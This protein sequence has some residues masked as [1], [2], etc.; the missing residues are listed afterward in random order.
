MTGILRNAAL[1]ALL[2]CGV[3]GAGAQEAL[4]QGTTTIVVPFAAGGPADGVAR[5]L[6]E[7]LATRFKRKYI[8]ENKTG[9]GG[10]IGAATV[11]R[12]A[13]DGQTLLFAV[14]SILTVN[15]HLQKRQ[16]F[17]PEALV[18]MAQI[19][20]TVLLLAV[21]PEKVKAADFRAMVAESAGKEFSFGSAGVGSPGHLAFEY[22]KQVSGM[23]GVHVP[24]RG[25]ALALQDLLS[26]NIDATFIVSGVLVPHVRSG[27]LKALAVS[28]GQ[29]VEALAEVPTA[30]QAG[31]P[32]FEARFYNFLMAP[33]ATPAPIR[34]TYEKELTALASNSA[35]LER[36]KAF[37]TIPNFASAKTAAEIIVRER[38]RW[39]KVIRTAGLGGK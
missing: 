33:A 11:A 31:I 35:F 9:A 34:A 17:A 32:N 8:V 30:V 37:S 13:P 4:P 23:K 19:G 22:L 39:G 28:A 6:A 24:Y 3:A 14:D 27:K 36:I 20:E 29:R 12:A 18:P 2:V 7:H 21:N 1:A 16:I 26:G 10:S 15:P 5:V 25:A 38:D